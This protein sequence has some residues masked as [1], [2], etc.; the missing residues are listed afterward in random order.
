M[1]RSAIHALA[2]VSL[3]AL[4]GVATSSH[5]VTSAKLG[6]LK[7]LDQ[8]KVGIVDP[9]GQSFCA[10]VGKFDKNMG[11]AFALSPDGYGSVAIDT[12]QGDF[13][14]GETYKLGLKAGGKKS[15][16]SGRATSDRSIVVQIGKNESFYSALKGNAPFG[17]ALPATSAD[18]TLSNFSQSYVDLVECSKTLTTPASGG[19][20]QMPAVKVK[21]VETAALSPVL[22]GRTPEA[23]KAE[24]EKAAAV[25]VAV[26]ET[27]GPVVIWDEPAKAE[28]KVL[29]STRVAPDVPKAAEDTG[30]A[31][32]QWDSHSEEAAQK[33]ELLRVAE[34]E[35][36]ARIAMLD[37]VKREAAKQHIAEFNTQKQAIDTK[38]ATLQKQAAAIESAQPASGKDKALK[39]SIVA[40]QAEI[41]RL[42][43]ERL[44]QTQDLTKKLAATQG[45]FSDKVSAIEAE[46]DQ[47]KKQLA[48]AQSAQKLAASR[49]SLLQ[50][51][52]DIART[53]GTQAEKDQKQ[54]AELQIRLQQ[55]ESTRRA[56]EANLAAVQKDAAAAQAFR[57]EMQQLQSKLAASENDKHVLEVRLAGI[58]KQSKLVNETLAAK[59]KA[60]SH[61]TEA[62][63]VEA[64]KLLSGYQNTVNELQGQ[65]K[66]QSDQ[67]AMLQ[68]RH[69]TL[70]QQARALELQNAKL[71]AEESKAKP[72]RKSL[73]IIDHDELPASLTQSKEDTVAL[74]S[75]ES[76]ISEL[77][78]E[79]ESSR[80]R[81]TA[82]Q[83]SMTAKASYSAAEKEQALSDMRSKLEQ[84]QK[85]IDLLKGENKNLSAKLAAPSPAQ[86]AALGALNGK[87][88]AAEA[89]LQR[90]KAQNAAFA[91]KP[92]PN[93]KRPSLVVLNADAA[94]VKPYE[95]IR[96]LEQKVAALEKAPKVAASN[97]VL[98]MP[99]AAT[100]IP[101]AD[102][103]DDLSPILSA[104]P[105]AASSPI[106]ARKPLQ[107][108]ASQDIRKLQAIE[109]AAGN[110]A[111]VQKAAPARRFAFTAAAPAK[112]VAPAVVPAV[113]KDPAFDGN[114]AAA[115]L[116]RI[117]SYH[118][119]GDED[120]KPAPAIKT[121]ER[122]FA[123]QQAPAFKPLARDMA[124]VT[125]AAPAPVAA[126]VVA[127][128]PVVAVSQ[129]APELRGYNKTASVAE[130]PVR[131]PV[132][133]PAAAVVAEQHIVSMEEPK[134][135]P[136]V[137][138]QPEWQRPIVAQKAEPVRKQASALSVEQILSSAGIRDAIF[139]PAQQDESGGIVRQWTV[140]GLS[141]MYEQMPAT[142]SFSENKQAYLARYREDCPAMTVQNG[143]SGKTDTGVYEVAGISCP[144]QGNAYSTSFVFWQDGRKFS[145]VLHSG[146]TSDAP[147]VMRRSAFAASGGA[148]RYD[149][150][151]RYG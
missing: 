18:F 30:A 84:S 136:V 75:A 64:N 122:V 67:Y 130:T 146:Y 72:A 151:R 46:R 45:E 63:R 36:Q 139:Q 74:A 69:E 148:G 42:E 133:R 83:N 66:Q 125:A 98:S 100:D 96:E 106:P 112:P 104:P 19:P 51:Q 10:M 80:I 77:E 41:L 55:A 149:C 15:T 35:K 37:A 110:I 135:Q 1:R 29:A 21:D 54:L 73:V 61:D 70:K 121:Q 53:K 123:T 81:A 9:E 147:Q 44:R 58:E 143:P 150:F 43:S 138:K 129:P 17:I 49:V 7:Q 119:A 28:R 91:S 137:I 102:V 82:L 62:Y 59:E 116:D 16:F 113:Q 6:T 26:A 127:Q 88:A 97:V 24:G 86:T 134:S 76:R 117:L 85:E 140:G 128:R 94:D 50:S 60:R 56:L 131:V 65:M 34:Q 145:A 101:A 33:A 52:L 92:E 40:K 8:W 141:G 103:V 25:A 2:T 20:G 14:P 13:I 111:P 109:P 126:P 132:S 99:T 120:S 27:S 107:Q 79:L 95:R 115:F 4:V 32:R 38:V 47:L 89:E 57:A 142:A 5:A 39:A 31:A 71:A 23:A 118:R 68:Q 93:V 87:L 22:K 12:A 48:D 90:L 144:V 114:R 78:R 105:V 11:L 124:P 3:A 108:Q